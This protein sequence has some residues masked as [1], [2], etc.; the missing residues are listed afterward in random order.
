[1]GGNHCANTTSN[2][3][4]FSLDDSFRGFTGSQSAVGSWF[5]SPQTPTPGPPKGAAVQLMLRSAP[6]PN[7]GPPAFAAGSATVAGQA[8][9]WAG[10]ATRTERS[11]AGSA[12]PS[13]QPRWRLRRRC[14]PLPAHRSGEA[15]VAGGRRGGVGEVAPL[16]G[17]QV[18]QTDGQFAE[19]QHADLVTAPPGH[20]AAVDHELHL[21]VDAIGPGQPELSPFARRVLFAPAHGDIDVALHLGQFA[22]DVPELAHLELLSS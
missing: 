4:Q 13:L 15:V 14:R 7:H 3:T 16:A 12:H 20:R 9:Y 10:I 2:Y 11:A 1:M 6:C 17:A 8:L 18:H 22:G 19:Q 21:L 5:P